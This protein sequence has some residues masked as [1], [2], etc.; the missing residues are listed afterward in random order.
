MVREVNFYDV[1]RWV[2]AGEK[3]PDYW[4]QQ[5]LSVERIWDNERGY[6]FIRKRVRCKDQGNNEAVVLEH[7][8]P[9]DFLPKLEEAI[10]FR[11]ELCLKL[12]YIRGIQLYDLLRDQHDY[13]NGGED[14]LW[15]H[16][17]KEVI[18]GVLYLHA[19][20]VVHLDIKP[21]NVLIERTTGRILL[22]DFGHSLILEDMNEPIQ[23]HF[24]IGTIGYALPECLYKK[25]FLGIHAD[26]YA[27][28]VLMYTIFT[29]YFPFDSNIKNIEQYYDK[30]MIR[31]N[32][33]K[34]P[35]KIRKKFRK[36]MLEKDQD[37]TE[38]LELCILE[39]EEQLKQWRKIPEL[40]R[41]IQ[42][43]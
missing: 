3:Y 8:P 24:C 19:H 30:E 6:Y 31:L 32:S 23:L 17:C 5:Y 28:T 35:K 34:L 21:E 18:S 26:L 37:V 15:Y 36:V 42:L 12:E 27:I 16:I 11:D 2:Y 1:P 9:S 33:K 25:P 40:I 10:F 22:I 41:D 43:N 4:T 39:P 20:N 29:S 38:L 14:N 7:L 13:H